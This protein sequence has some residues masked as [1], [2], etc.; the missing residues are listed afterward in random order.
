MKRTDLILSDERPVGILDSFG[1][2]HAYCACLQPD[3]VCELLLKCRYSTDTVRRWALE[4]MCMD[5]DH[6]QLDCHKHLIRVLTSDLAEAKYRDSSSLGYLMSNIAE[7]AAIDE[8]RAIIIALLSSS[9]VVARRRGY[10]LIGKDIGD[11]QPE[12]DRVWKWVSDP[13]CAWLITKTFP[14]EYLVQNRKALASKFSEEWQFS[15][16]YLR[17]GEVHPSLLRELQSINEIRYCYVLA[18]LGRKLTLSEAKK[19]VD[20]T[21]HDDRFGLLVWSLGK[22]KQWNALRYIETEIANTASMSWPHFSGQEV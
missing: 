9:Y 18:K 21:P 16:L 14:V 13:E 22:M 4:R 20:R 3:E 15:R 8:R 12:V 17:I 10:K 5:L 6:A 11:L 2:R 19:I 1:L 7:H